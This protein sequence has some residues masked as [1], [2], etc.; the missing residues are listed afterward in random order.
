MSN[1]A[2][3]KSSI[4]ICEHYIQSYSVMTYQDLGLT[5]LAGESIDWTLLSVLLL[6]EVSRVDLT[7]TNVLEGV[8]MAYG[9]AQC[10]TLSTADALW[11]AD[12][13]A[14]WGFFSFLQDNGYSVDD[15]TSRIIRKHA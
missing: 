9:W 1:R 10:R 6:H 2:R 4:T 12:T 8:D 14:T 11:N 15:A 7:Y 13:Y 3:T 5:K